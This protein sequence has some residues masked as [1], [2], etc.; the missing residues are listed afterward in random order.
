MTSHQGAVPELGDPQLA[1]ERMAEAYYAIGPDW[2]FRY[3]NASAEAFWG[4]PRAQLLGRSMCAVLPKFERQRLNCASPMSFEVLAS[5][6]PS[7]SSS[8]MSNE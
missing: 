7:S 6:R 5:G 2:C 1:L 3:A 8:V 4:R